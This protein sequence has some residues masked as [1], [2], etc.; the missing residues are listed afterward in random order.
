MDFLPAYPE[1]EAAH[2]SGKPQLIWTEI[3]ADIE[4]AVSL[5]LKL[6]EA[7]PMSFMLESV[8]GG[9]VRGRY[10]VIGMAPDLIWRCHGQAAEINR[11]AL[12]SLTTFDPEAKPSLDSLRDLIAESQIDIPTNLPPMAAGL[13]G[14]LG[15]DMIR[16]VEKLPEPN[17]DVPR[18]ARCHPDPAERDRHCR[19]Y[20]RSG[21]FGDTCVVDR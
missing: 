16:L 17:P 3:V 2:R 5:M 8:T 10:S 7:D 13:F 11:D 1:F 14:Y 6:T 9:E 4:T 18:P 15:Y 19:Q 21:N 12:T 20:S